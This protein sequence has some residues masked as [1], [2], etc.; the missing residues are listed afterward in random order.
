MVQE[1]LYGTELNFFIFYVD[2]KNRVCYDRTIGNEWFADR[3]VEKLKETKKSAYYLNT[4]PKGYK[5]FY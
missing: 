5:F 4:I 1:E 3:R 2:N